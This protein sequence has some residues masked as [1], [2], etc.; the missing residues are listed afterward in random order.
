M[1]PSQR[2]NRWNFSRAGLDRIEVVSKV[3]RVS[4]H[5]R[6]RIPVGHPTLRNHFPVDPQTSQPP[7]L[8]ASCLYEAKQPASEALASARLQGMP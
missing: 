2:P 4:T 3:E 1:L 8:N 5:D 7:S 6:A